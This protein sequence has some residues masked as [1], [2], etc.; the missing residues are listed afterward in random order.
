MSV[1]GLC[2]EGCSGRLGRMLMICA[3]GS[4]H[5]GSDELVC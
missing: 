1:G 3:R 5:G 2:I 4:V